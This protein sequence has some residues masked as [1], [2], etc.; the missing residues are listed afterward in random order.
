MLGLRNPH[1]AIYSR[2]VITSLSTPQQANFALKYDQRQMRLGPIPLRSTPC[3]READRNSTERVPLETFP[4]IFAVNYS[5][6]IKSL[7]RYLLFVYF[8]KRV[9]IGKLGRR[10]LVAPGTLS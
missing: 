9:D 2:D 3:L 5:Y 6:Q 7:F 10:N 1:Y 4:H 8:Y